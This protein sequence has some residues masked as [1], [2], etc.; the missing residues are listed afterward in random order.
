[1]EFLKEFLPS[2]KS[3]N[4]GKSP[5]G[6]AFRKRVQ[7]NKARGLEGKQAALD[8]ALSADPQ[9]HSGL[10]FFDLQKLSQFALELAMLDW[11]TGVD[12]RPYISVIKVAFDT[13]L[14]ARPDILPG[15]RNPGF[16]AVISSMMGWDLPFSFDLPS[17]EEQKDDMVCMDRW[18]IAGLCDPSSW[19]KK[20]SAPPIK[21]KFINTCL[22]DYWALL[23]EQVDPEEGIKRCIKN[24]ERRATH[25]TFK[26]LPPLDAGGKYNQL[27]VDYTLAAVM[28]RRGISSGTV[29]DWVWD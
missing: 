22:E 21:N 19:S 23:T 6:D 7:E 17:A 2:T 20:D 11:R 25:Q 3:D 27:Y 13:A 10:L 26:N 28:K 8:K 4:A 24:Y 29:H 5:E 15:D 14:E 9:T 12:P 18:I 1:M 16:M